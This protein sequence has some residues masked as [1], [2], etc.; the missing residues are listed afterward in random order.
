MEALTLPILQLYLRNHKVSWQVS[1][2]FLLPW[3]RGLAYA[4]RSQWDL[5]S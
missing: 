3:G 1:E 4:C 2:V 5:E